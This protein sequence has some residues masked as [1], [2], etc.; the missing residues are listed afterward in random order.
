MVCNATIEQQPQPQMRAIC[1]QTSEP[2][3]MAV[4]PW[5]CMGY[6]GEKGTVPFQAPFLV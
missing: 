3:E 6:P 2:G 5:P 4:S 1:L